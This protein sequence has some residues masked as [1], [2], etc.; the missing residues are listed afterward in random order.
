M[1]L[2]EQQA[3]QHLITLNM[4]AHITVLKDLW[5]CTDLTGKDRRKI[6][7]MEPKRKKLVS[8]EVQKYSSLDYVGYATC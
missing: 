8:A 5:V 7:N 3:I 1:T 6:I 2:F 4:A